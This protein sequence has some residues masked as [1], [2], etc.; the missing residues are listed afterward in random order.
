MKKQFFIEFYNTIYDSIKVQIK[1]ESDLKTGR[2]LI[3]L[4]LYDPQPPSE[5]MKTLIEKIGLSVLGMFGSLRATLLFAARVVCRIFDKNVYNSAVKMVLFDQIYFTSVQ[6]L[7]LFLTVAVILGSVL[8]FI[9]MLVVKELGM[10]QYIGRFMIGFMV[11]ELS[12]FITVILIALRSSSAINTEIAVMKVNKEIKTLEVFQIDT[13]NYLFLP[14]VINGVASVVFLNSLFSIVVLAT[15]LVFSK[16]IFQMSFEVYTDVLVNSI[17]FSD[18]I[19]L[20]LKCITYGVFITLIP[21]MYGLGATKELTSI[22]IA[23]LNGMVR[24]FLAI[25]IIEVLSLIL[26]L[27]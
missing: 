27:I 19:I 10:V 5:A 20:Y 4:I 21:I 17:Y 22:P 16:L 2:C 26:K 24:V 11:N 15:G 6:I 25:V 1:Y 8:V 7:P 13:I 23:V 12:P 3:N 9:L 14:R 18:I